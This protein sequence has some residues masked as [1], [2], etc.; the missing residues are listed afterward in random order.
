MVPSVWRLALW[1]LDSLSDFEGPNTGEKHHSGKVAL[2]S[3]IISLYE[4]VPFMKETVLTG[5]VQRSL[6]PCR[7]PGYVHGESEAALEA[8]ASLGAASEA[9]GLYKHCDLKGEDQL[10]GKNVQDVGKYTSTVQRRMLRERRVE[11][12][13]A[14]PDCRHPRTSHYGS[15][16]GGFIYAISPH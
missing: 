5:L 4:K 14:L 6:A 8:L 3:L 10:D 13:K 9:I 11:A 15:S 16:G 7:S 12:H 1:L 2:G